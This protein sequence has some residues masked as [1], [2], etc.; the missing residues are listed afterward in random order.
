[1]KKLLVFGLLSLSAI[2]ITVVTANTLLSDSPTK[3][4][5]MACEGCEGAVGD[6]G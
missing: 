5:Q 3:V 6:G 1:M 4:I 2:T